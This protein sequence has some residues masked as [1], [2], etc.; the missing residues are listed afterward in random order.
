MS[1]QIPHY[2]AYACKATITPTTV[3]LNSPTVETTNR[4]LRHYARENLDGRFLRVQ[5]TDGM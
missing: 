5:F 2:C 1:R 3:Y 4:I